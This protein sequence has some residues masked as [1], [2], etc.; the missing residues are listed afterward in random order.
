[1]SLNINHF[2]NNYLNT[3]KTLKDDY[4]LVYNYTAGLSEHP[5]HT[6]LFIYKDLSFEIK[7]VWYKYPVPKR[8]YSIYKSNLI[9]EKIIGLINQLSDLEKI[10]LKKLYATFTGKY[11]PED[12]SHTSL[13]F[14]HKGKTH[15][16]N[17]S[18]Y[19]MGKE[20]FVSD[21]EQ[22]ILKLNDHISAW[23]LQLLESITNIHKEK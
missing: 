4:L 22:L 2:K 20:L 23:E 18:S 6:N 13:Y 10:E 12:V 17:M 16:I 21:E 8:L 14:Q 15:S 5:R 3:D 9:P 1:M 7:L 11:T 19:L